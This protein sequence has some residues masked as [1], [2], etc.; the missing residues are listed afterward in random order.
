[1]DQ[2]Y[3]VERGVVTRVNSLNSENDFLIS[4]EDTMSDG[5]RSRSDSDTGGAGGSQKT[6]GHVY[7][8]HI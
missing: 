6:S 8:K 1:M 5:I 2:I 3:H 4:E 7:R